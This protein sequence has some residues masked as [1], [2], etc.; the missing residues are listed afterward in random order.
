MHAQSP[1]YICKSVFLGFKSHSWSILKLS[2]I[3][4]IPFIFVYIN[5]HFILYV[6]I[7]GNCQCQGAS[8]LK[9]T[10]STTGAQVQKKL[11]WKATIVNDCEC[12]QSGIKLSCDGFE[13]VEKIDPSILLQAGGVCLINGGGPIQA[14]QSFS[15]TYAWDNQYPF[16]PLS[17]TI[18]C[19][20][21]IWG[22]WSLF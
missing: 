13:T 14:H 18:G 1:G 17:S 16:K 8:D 15:F 11:Q 20:V 21:K 10:Q 9:I 12:P 2:E 22:T 4:Y 6:E 5:Y 19:W 3:F 7:T